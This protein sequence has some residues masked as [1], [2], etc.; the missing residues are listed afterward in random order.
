MIVIGDQ[1][2]KNF[3]NYIRLHYGIH[4]KMENLDRRQAWTP[5][6]KDEF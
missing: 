2:F 4:F 1:E 3:S 5:V 6:I